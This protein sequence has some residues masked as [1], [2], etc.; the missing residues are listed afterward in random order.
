[1]IRFF[2]RGPVRSLPVSATSSSPSLLFAWR[3]ERA[4]I[5]DATGAQPIDSG[6]EDNPCRTGV[7]A[8]SEARANLWRTRS[9]P[10]LNC[11]GSATYPN[12]TTTGVQASATA[13]QRKGSQ[14][15]VRARKCGKIQEIRWLTFVAGTEKA[16]A[17]RGKTVR[18]PCS[19]RVY[20][21]QGSEEAH[22][23]SQQP[24]LPQALVQPPPEACAPRSPGAL[25]LVE[26]LPASLTAWEAARRL[27]H[28]DRLLFLDSAALDSPLGRYSY[29][30]ADPFFCLVHEGTAG[31][32]PF[33]QLNEELARHRIETIPGLPPFQGGAAGLFGY[34]LCHHVERLP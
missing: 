27:A 17:R 2:P 29:V 3:S 7:L 23:M 11:D 8:C 33:A 20:N 28:L 9:E 12:G 22:T 4:R 18:C 15:E 34:D 6:H 25:P 24:A 32:D 30:A 13:A 10:A 14:P 26:E 16:Q 5:L 31:P 19:L 21:D 1:M